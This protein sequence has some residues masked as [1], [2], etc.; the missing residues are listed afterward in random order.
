MTRTQ[1]EL[2]LSFLV[3]VPVVRDGTAIVRTPEDAAAQF[4]ELRQAGQECFAVAYLNAK[5]RLLDKRVITLGI[6]DTSL[7]HAREV[8]RPAIVAQASAV[9]LCHNHPSGDVTPSAE[10]VRIT[11]Q[12]IQA[13]RV[14][15]ISVLDHVVIGRVR[16]EGSNER[17]FCSLRESGV[18]EFTD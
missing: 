6:V 11:R 14:I 4:D 5:N 16:Q 1:G 3:T 18:V 7:V 17:G 8:F 15:G 10:D 12:L 13:G 2:G 9:V